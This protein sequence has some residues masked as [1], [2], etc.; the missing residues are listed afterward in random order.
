MQRHVL[1]GGTWAAF[2]FLAT[3]GL[4]AATEVQ[5]LDAYPDAFFRGVGEHAV[6]AVVAAVV[7]GLV[8]AAWSRRQDVS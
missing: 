2:S 8:V 6:P 4:M 1:R 3:V 7:V 5:T